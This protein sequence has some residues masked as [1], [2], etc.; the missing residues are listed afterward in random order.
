M[1]DKRHKS[2]FICPKTKELLFNITKPDGESF[3]ESEHG[4][5]YR[6]ELGFPNLIFPELNKETEETKSFYD[7]RVEE[8]DKYLP[9]TFFTHN[10]DEQTVRNSLVDLLEVNQGDRVLDL[11]CGTGRDSEIIAQRIGGAGKLYMLDIAPKM[12]RRCQEK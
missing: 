1:N 5:S 4:T 7:E 10:E 6:F 3:L 2:P 12:L 11:A 8:Y 9:L